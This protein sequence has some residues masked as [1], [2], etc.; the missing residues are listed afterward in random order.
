MSYAINSTDTGF[1]AINSEADLLPGET[2]SATLPVIV[3]TQAQLDA[4]A[5]ATLDPVTVLTNALIAKG[6]I[7]QLDISAAQTPMVTAALSAMR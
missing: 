1:R 2:F 4:Q 3:P 6:V 7:S 5:Q